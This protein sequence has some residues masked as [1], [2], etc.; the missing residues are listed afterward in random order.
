MSGTCY[1]MTQEA[2][3]R[4]VGST[5]FL[6]ETVRQNKHRF[7]HCYLSCV[8][9]RTYE[10]YRMN[11]GVQYIK[12]VT[13]F[14]VNMNVTRKTLYVV[15]DFCHLSHIQQREYLAFARR[16]L[17]AGGRCLFNR[18]DVLTLQCQLYKT[19]IPVAIN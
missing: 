16:V 10:D 11:T 5:T 8:T 15:D 3:R 2:G 9:A 6:I 12:R 1:Y 17:R 14:D 13:T 7:D 18:I 4:R 19:P